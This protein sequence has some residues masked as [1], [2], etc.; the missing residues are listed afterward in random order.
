MGE[1]EARRTGG[2]A[3]NWRPVVH[4]HTTQDQSEEKRKKLGREERK[5]KD[6]APGTS[7]GNSS[8]AAAH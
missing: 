4:T 5:G 3:R 6:P 1:T 2:R 8:R 7:A